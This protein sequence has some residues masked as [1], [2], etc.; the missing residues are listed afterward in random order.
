MAGD[1]RFKGP[2]GEKG[3]K[4][5][6]GD[7]GA[8]GSA[9]KDAEVTDLQLA[10]ISNAVI[11]NVK[12]DPSMQPPDVE[13]LTARILSRLPSIEVRN[14]GP[15]QVISLSDAARNNRSA[16]MIMDNQN[17]FQTRPQPE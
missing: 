4:G 10:A 3:E 12:S 15:T 6:P 8:T 16:V 5:D 14:A 7:T 1:E 2:P 17:N 13:E 9:G 11:Q